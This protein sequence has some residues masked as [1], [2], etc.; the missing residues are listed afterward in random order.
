MVSAGINQGSSHS[1]GH[2]KDFLI[3]I[4]IYIQYSS[5]RYEH[6]QFQLSAR[7]LFKSAIIIT[8]C[9]INIV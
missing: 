5:I 3:S 6:T 7:H 1:L 2:S 4:A 8:K 9:Y